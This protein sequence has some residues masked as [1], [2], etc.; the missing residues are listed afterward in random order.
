MRWMP[1]HISFFN[2]FLSFLLSSPSSRA[3]SSPD[4]RHDAAGFLSLSLCERNTSILASVF[5]HLSGE[6]CRALYFSTPHRIFTAKNQ[7]NKL[8]TQ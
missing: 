6:I 2:Y 5:A 1:A 4:G 7:T 8:E 3:V